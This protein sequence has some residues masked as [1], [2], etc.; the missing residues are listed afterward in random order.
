MTM[1]L[2]LKYSS[3]GKRSNGQVHSDRTQQKAPMQLGTSCDW[4]LIKLAE[5]DFAVQYTGDDPDTLF[6]SN[7]SGDF[8]PPFHTKEL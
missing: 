6:P 3:L 5:D 8:P 4:F 7:M 1:F 2:S